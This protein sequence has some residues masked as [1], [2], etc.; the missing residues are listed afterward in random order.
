METSGKVWPL[1]SSVGDTVAPG[2]IADSIRQV[3]SSDPSCPR[4]LE[5][6]SLRN[7]TRNSSQATAARFL[8]LR[9]ILANQRQWSAWSGGNRQ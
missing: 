5:L 4:R 2:S 1:A 6:D 8:L 7:S 3:V 9:L